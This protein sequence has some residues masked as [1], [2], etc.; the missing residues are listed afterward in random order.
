MR[1]I[2]SILLVAATVLVGCYPTSR[3]HT[4]TTK[5]AAP[6]VT[7]PPRFRPMLVTTLGTHTSFDGQLRIDVSED[8][9]DLSRS[10]AHGD[11]PGNG[12]KGWHTISPTGWRAQSGWFVLVESESRTWVYDGG[13]QLLVYTETWDDKGLNTTVSASDLSDSVPAEVLARIPESKRKAMSRRE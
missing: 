7:A 13:R 5:T 2:I 3:V 4:Q 6:T 12:V 1:N 10:F 9:V 11:G 8:D